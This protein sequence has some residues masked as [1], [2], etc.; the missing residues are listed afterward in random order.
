MNYT[1]FCCSTS[2]K[3]PLP[4]YHSTSPH[5]TCYYP[6]LTSTHSHTLHYTKASTSTTHF[7]LFTVPLHAQLAGMYLKSDP[8]FIT[9]LSCSHYSTTTPTTL[10][11]HSVYILCPHPLPTHTPPFLLVLY[12][13][14]I[15]PPCHLLARPLRPLPQFGEMARKTRRHFKPA[16]V[17]VCIA[18]LSP[19][20]APHTAAVPAE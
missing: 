5:R 10:T 1:Y 11:L 12:P 4:P 13:H 9:H 7:L 3:L 18:R 20:P 16:N 2:A 19:W 15:L 17:R 14:P 8:C 6:N